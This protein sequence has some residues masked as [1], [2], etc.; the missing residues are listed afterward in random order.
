[1]DALRRNLLGALHEANARM[2]TTRTTTTT[3]K[4]SAAVH[5]IK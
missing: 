1:V 4:P 3:M 2:R 5:W